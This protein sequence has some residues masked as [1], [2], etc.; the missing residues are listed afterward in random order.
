MLIFLASW[1]SSS[2]SQLGMFLVQLRRDAVVVVQEKRLQDGQ[3]DGFVAAA[4][5]RDEHVGFGQ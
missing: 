1:K 3:L 2:S 4:V 5:A